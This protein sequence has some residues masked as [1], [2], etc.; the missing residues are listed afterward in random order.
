[1]ANIKFAVVR[2]DPLIEQT[3][4]ERIT[5]QNVLMIASGG[6]TALSLKSKFPKINFTLFD[7]NSSQIQ[8]VK[9]KIKALECYGNHSFKEQFNINFNNPKGLNNCGEFES[10]FNCFRQFLTEFILPKKNILDIFLEDEDPNI[11]LNNK[12]WSVAFDLFFSNSLLLAMFGPAAIQHAEPNSYPRYFQ[13]AF[14]N[15]FYRKDYKKNYFL[16]HMFLGYYLDNINAQP[17]Y[18][19]KKNQNI[20]FEY[21]NDK[22]LNVENINKFQLVSLSNIFDWMSEEEVLTHLKYLENNLLSGTYI[23][24]RQLNNTK[25]YLSKV[26]GFKNHNQLENALLINDKSLF[27]NK[28]NI[29]EK[30]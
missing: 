17:Y 2:E 23:I 5:P 7:I 22:L 26:H 16:H 18:L 20:Q 4:I 15:G 10:L 28:I 9:N 13:K 8:L 27:Y 3:L 11:L 19:H 24:F 25:N 30:V 21:I 29:W 6:C 1:M 14:E 12:Y